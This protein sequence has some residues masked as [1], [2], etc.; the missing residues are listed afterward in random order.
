MT[1]Q[2]MLQVAGDLRKQAD[3]YRRRGDVVLAR[4]AEE[5]LRVLLPRKL[6]ARFGL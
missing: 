2:K 1:K 5:S 3:E 6:W 4:Q